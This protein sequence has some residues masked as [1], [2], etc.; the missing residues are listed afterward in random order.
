MSPLIAAEIVTAERG[1][2]F[3]VLNAS[4]FLVSD[5]VIAGIVIISLIAYCFDLFIH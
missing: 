5:V 4:A 2:G 3:M 1:I